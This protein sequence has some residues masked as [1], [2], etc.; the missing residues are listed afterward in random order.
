MFLMPHTPAYIP[1]FD[2]VLYCDLEW[3]TRAI[4]YSKQILVGVH[5]AGH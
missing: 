4:Y 5:F 1:L 3:E 2:E